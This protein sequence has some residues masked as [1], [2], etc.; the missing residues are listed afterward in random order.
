MTIMRMVQ[1]TSQAASAINTELFAGRPAW[2]RHTLPFISVALALLACF[3]LTPVMGHETPFII[4]FLPIIVS[5]WYGGFFP[6]LSATVLSS[7]IALYFFISPQLSF[8]IQDPVS[9]FRLSI[10]IFDGLIISWLCQKLHN[11]IAKRD[12]VDL[13]IRRINANLEQI[14]RERTQSVHEMQQRDR[15]NFQRLQGMIDH[16]PIGVLMIDES[17][18]VLQINNMFCMSFH[19]PEK[20]D[21]FLGKKLH[22]FNDQR[23][24]AVADPGRVNADTDVHLE[25]KKTVIDYQILMKDGRTLRRDYL[26][27][28]GEGNFQGHVLLYRDITQEKCIDTTRSEFMSLA[29]HQLRTPL[30]ILKWSYNRLSKHLAGRLTPQDTKLFHE[31]RSA[32]ERMTQTI[33]TM[34][35]ISRIEAGK[36]LPERNDVKLRLFLYELEASLKTQVDAKKQQCTVECPPAIIVETDKLILTEILSNLMTNAIK[37]TPERGRIFVSAERQGDYVKI[38]VQ[39]TGYGI[40]LHQ[41]QRIFTKFFRADNVSQRDPEGF[42]L[43][44]YLVHLLVHMLKGSISFVSKENEGTTF[45]M[46]L[47][48]H[49]HE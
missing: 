40:P 9:V 37:Y 14:I 18:S 23:L 22:E 25:S 1:R 17:R 43:G 38:D 4:F 35:A 26:P 6:G 10:F 28:F 42:G 15:A 12:D 49:N 46:T 21:N 32:I 16:L 39:D 31:C 34:L 47:P 20:A 27:I 36:V 48:L 30:T 11:A 13:E 7:F 33:D 2:F 5:A 29:S 44:L 8:H 45:T 41:Q 19:M 24:E 3:G